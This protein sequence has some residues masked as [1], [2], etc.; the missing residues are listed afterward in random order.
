MPCYG[1][2][3]VPA[4]SV[5]RGLC[6]L[7]SL[8]FVNTAS[9]IPSRAKCSTVEDQVLCGTGGGDGHVWRSGGGDKEA[10]E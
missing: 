6:Y 2:R 4:C 9:S 1:M 7:P 5:A 3:M 8:L 10:V